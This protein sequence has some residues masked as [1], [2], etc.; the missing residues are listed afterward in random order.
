V[1][2][3]PL[4]RI[5]L[6]IVLWLAVAIP[7]LI[8]VNP[9]C[10]LLASREVSPAALRPYFLACLLVSLPG[11]LLLTALLG[12]A[13]GAGWTRLTLTRSVTDLVLTALIV[14]LAIGSIG[15][16]VI[17]APIAIGGAQ[18]VISVFVIAALIKHRERWNLGDPAPISRWFDRKTWGALLDFGLPAQLA[19][20][21]TLGAFA[22]LAQHVARDGRS[23]VVA[24]GISMLL[25]SLAFNLCAGVGRASGILVGQLAGARAFDRMRRVVRTGFVAALAVAAVPVTIYA[26]F[27]GALVGLFTADPGAITRGDAAVAVIALA[28]PA[29][30]V[31]QLFLFA[32]IAL[33]EAR[34]A[35]LLGIAAEIVGLSFALAVP[36]DERLPIAALSIVISNVVR[37]ALYAGLWKLVVLPRIERT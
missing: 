19:R 36:G 37:A 21:A 12:G 10:E 34:L 9:I 14:P 18:L 4:P 30:A 24:Y 20:V 32:F 28:I 7:A 16:G 23:A 33:K 26:I 11:V 31:S 2:A 27:G 15:L 3:I 8:F 5:A 22:Y 35:G 17:G 29:A 6:T 13:S 25:L 1:S